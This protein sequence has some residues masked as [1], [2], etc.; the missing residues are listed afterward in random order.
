MMPGNPKW[1][2]SSKNLFEYNILGGIFMCKKPNRVEKSSICN[3][4]P[5]PDFFC[6]ARII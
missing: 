1:K 4:L 2:M 6:V 5:G 3:A